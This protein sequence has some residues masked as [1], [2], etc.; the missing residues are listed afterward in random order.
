MAASEAWST[1]PL[2]EMYHK[3]DTSKVVLLEK[4]PIPAFIPVKPLEHMGL[5]E[6]E[7]TVVTNLQT[8]R[9]PVSGTLGKA[10]A[11]LA[12]LDRRGFPG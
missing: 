10:A 6:A 9:T 5:N 4:L 1:F 8:P 12:L 11:T 3:T 7:C 2:T